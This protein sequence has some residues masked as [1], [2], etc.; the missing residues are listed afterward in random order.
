MGGNFK[1]ISAFSNIYSQR[2]FKIM[3][4]S[5]KHLKC[6]TDIYSMSTQKQASLLLHPLA[7]VRHKTGGGICKPGTHAEFHIHIHS[8]I[9]LF[10]YFSVYPYTGKTMDVEIV[11]I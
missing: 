11:K 3:Q 8:F 2:Q 5:Y 1:I 6:I 4:F 7:M 9:H 10:L